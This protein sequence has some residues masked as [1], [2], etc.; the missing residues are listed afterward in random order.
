M[1]V[2][3]CWCCCC[4]NNLQSKTLEILAIVFQAISFIFLSCTLAIIKWSKIPV[5]NLLLFILMFII[6]ILIII[7]TSFIRCWREKNLIKNAKKIIGQRLASTCFGLIIFCFILCVI[8]E[9]VI[10]FGFSNVDY[11]CRNVNYNNPEKSSNYNYYYRKRNLGNDVDCNQVGPEYDANVITDVEYYISYITFTYLELSFI[12]G[13]WIWHVLR[14]R[15]IQGLDGPSPTPVQSVMYDQYGRQVVVVQ[16]G[17]VVI[18]DGQPHIAVPAQNQNNNQF[19]QSN[20]QFIQSNNQFNQ[21]HNQFNHFNSKQYNYKNN[22][23]QSQNISNQIN[24]N[25]IPDSQ[26]FNLQ[27]KPH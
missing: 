9:F 21:S 14:R 12:L 24:N 19:N 6:N 4:F 15:I 3:C 2:F 25:P 8:E 22:I 16:Q 1:G 17:D 18:M 5:A 10:S 26:E 7:F 20:N 11:P 23:G 27:E 13:V